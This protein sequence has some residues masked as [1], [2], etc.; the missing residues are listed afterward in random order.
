MTQG[1]Y[2]F[3]NSKARYDSTHPPRGAS[4]TKG[5]KKALHRR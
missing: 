1:E 4:H 3:G 5:N 2:L